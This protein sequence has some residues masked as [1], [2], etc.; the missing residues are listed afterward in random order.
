MK[1]FVYITLL[2]SFWAVNAQAQELNATV[3]V[4]AQKV[5]N[6]D[7]SIFKALESS[8]TQ[9]LNN[10]R[11]TSDVYSAEER[12]ECGF[13]INITDAPTSESF[14]AEITV[15][16][17]RPVYGSAFFCTMFSHKDDQFSFGY[18]PFQPMEFSETAF[19]NNLTSVLAFYAYM[20][21]GIDY[22]SFSPDGGSPFFNKARQIVQN[23]QQT[24]EAG[25][26]SFDKAGRNRFTLSED[27]QSPAFKS[28]R[29]FLYKYH[30]EGFDNFY[31]DFENARKKAIEALTGIEDI[32]KQR[33][34]SFLLQVFFN[35]KRD[36]AINMLKGLPQSETANLVQVMRKV[37]GAYAS[38]W[39]EIL[40]TTN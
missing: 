21:I 1:K 12:I 32:Y 16:S 22:D 29:V 33:P 26:K 39:D 25:W 5:T 31:N 14:V 6:M 24:S 38:R 27:I 15:N 36:E 3:K 13:L 4:T 18:V 2:A 34:N 17:R 40:K 37:D 23:A 35:S 20:V 28:Y 9:F 11:W 8:V 10:T 19:M 7:P 30:R